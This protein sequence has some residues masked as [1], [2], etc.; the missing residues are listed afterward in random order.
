MNVRSLIVPGLVFF[1]G[2][3]VG[4]L[5]GIK[6]L[7]RG[8]MAVATMGGVLPGGDHRGHRRVSHRPMRRR[9]ARRSAK[10]A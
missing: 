1:A 6:P 8:A 7:V 3:V 2:A 5:F 10:A 9:T 4:R